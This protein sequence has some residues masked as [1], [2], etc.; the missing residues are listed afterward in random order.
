M[1]CNHAEEN[2]NAYKILVG[3]PVGKR[4]LMRSI[5]YYEK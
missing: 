1:R 3:E 4:L 2:G 5:A